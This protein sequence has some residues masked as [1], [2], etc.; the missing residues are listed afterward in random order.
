MKMNSSAFIRSRC[1]ENGKRSFSIHFIVDAISHGDDAPALCTLPTLEQA[2]MLCRYING[3]NMDK[4]ERESVSV[5]LNVEA[6]AYRKRT[7]AATK[8]PETA[9]NGGG[10]IAKNPGLS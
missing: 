6:K 3:G 9:T 8:V 10:G 5:A 4:Q 2:A 1:D 7:Q